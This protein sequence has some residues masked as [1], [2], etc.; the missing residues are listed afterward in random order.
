MAIV[1]P[2]WDSR[3][4]VR[5]CVRGCQLELGAPLGSMR[6]LGQ[7]W[8]SSVCAPA[9]LEHQLGWGAWGDI[10]GRETCFLCCSQLSPPPGLGWGSETT[11]PLRC[12]WRDA[13]DWGN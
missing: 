6:P 13:E 5:S 4:R 9:A 8:A 7:G 1:Q 3:D 11:A 2:S 10:D 12:T